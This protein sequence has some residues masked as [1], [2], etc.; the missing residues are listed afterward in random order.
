LSG[1]SAYVLG[2]LRIIALG[3]CL[4]ALTG[5]AVANEATYCIDTKDRPP[6]AYRGEPSVKWRVFRVPASKLRSTCNYT[7]PRIVH[8]CT[9]P[10]D[11]YWAVIIAGNI[12]A[13]EYACRLAYEKAHMPPHFWG[14]PEIELPETI[15]WLADQKRLAH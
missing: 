3:L 7:G 9:Y 12:S 13:A 5:S 11:G 1:S 4:A 15:K 10:T 6:V 8:S 2:M 14:D